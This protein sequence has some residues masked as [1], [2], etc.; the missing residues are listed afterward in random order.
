L[1]TV[2]IKTTKI[3]LRIM[4]AL[5]VLYLI[6]SGESSKVQFKERANDASDIAT[7]IVVLLSPAIAK[8]YVIDNHLK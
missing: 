3:D 7:E 1:L 5:E 8:P 2:S 4:D 6:Q